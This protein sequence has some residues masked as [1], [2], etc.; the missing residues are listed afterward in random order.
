M[1]MR[2]L[3]S[4]VPSHL[5]VLFAA[6][7]LLPGPG[8]LNPAPAFA[9][10]S[11]GKDAPN[12]SHRL[13]LKD[14]SYQVVSKYEI[15]GDRVRYMS[16]ERDEWEELPSALVDWPATEKFEKERSTPA[17]PEAA[18]IDKETDAER[19]AELSS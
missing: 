16:A 19:E 7:L 8:T 11:P 2:S 4:S 18:A 15:H 12:T 5:V 9:Q 14:G 1:T 10:D 3:W 17:I 13:I 6:A